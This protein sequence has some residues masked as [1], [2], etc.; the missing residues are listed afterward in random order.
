M[1]AISP[2]GGSRS[3]VALY[4]L[5]V[6]PPRLGQVMH[7]LGIDPEFGVAPKK[8]ASRNAAPA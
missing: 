8:R 7:G 6:M 3:D 5:A 4:R 2:K 1:G